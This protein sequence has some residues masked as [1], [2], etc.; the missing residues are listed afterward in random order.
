MEMIDLSREIYHRTQTHPS[1]PPVMMTIWNDH[2]EKKVA[3]N[4]TSCLSVTFRKHPKKQRHGS[5]LGLPYVRVL[6]L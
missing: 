5:I 3:G 4:T 6:P 2:T 1:H